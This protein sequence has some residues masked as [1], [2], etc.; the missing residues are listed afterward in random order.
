MRT[1]QEALK[2]R[3]KLQITV[4]KEPSG[5]IYKPVR[6]FEEAGFPPNVLSACR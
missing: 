4:E 3:E 5:A 6:S 2:H 1:A